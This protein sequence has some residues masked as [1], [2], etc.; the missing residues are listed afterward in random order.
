MIATGKDIRISPHFLGVQKTSKGGQLMMGVDAQVV[1][2]L[3]LGDKHTVALYIVNQE[4]FFA[5]KNN[6]PKPDGLALIKAER[7]E[8][9][10]KHGRT[11][12]RD[13]EE[14]QVHQLSK[15]AAILVCDP[16]DMAQAPPAGWNH[17]IWAKMLHKPYRERCI[18][19]GALLAAEVD[20]LDKQL[21]QS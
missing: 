21:L 7:Q 13:I 8:Q 20:R 16:I 4:Q 1:M 15:A 12:E 3:A 18:I 9:I 6:P 2:D 14:N 5:I 10:T 17:S 19:A 11:V